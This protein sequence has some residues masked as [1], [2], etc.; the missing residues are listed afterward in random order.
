MGFHLGNGFSMSRGVHSIKRTRCKNGALVSTVFI[1][2]DTDYYETAL[3]VNGDSMV[4]HES[5]Q[6]LYEAMKD[7]S[8]VVREMGGVHWLNWLA[9]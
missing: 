6:T 2:M 3:F 5:A 9:A 8:T 7:H 1:R 4:T